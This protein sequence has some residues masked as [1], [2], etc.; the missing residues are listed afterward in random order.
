MDS[1]RLRTETGEIEVAGR[2]I[3]TGQDGSR[4]L[5]GRDG[6]LWTI[7]PG[8]VLAHDED[9]RPFEGVSKDEMARILLAELPQGFQVVQTAHYVIAYE[10]SRDY[11]LWCGGLFER[12]F[13]AFNNYFSRRGFELREP[14]VP[15]AAIVY[16]SRES[17]IRNNRDEVGDGVT[18]ILGFYNLETNR[19]KLFD[20]SGGAAR[21]NAAQIN[22]YLNRPE[23]L[24]NLATVIHEATHQ[25]A[26]NSG[27]NC[28]WTDTPLWLSEGIAVY[29]ETPDVR[30]TR[31]WST[32]DV[33]NRPR[34]EQ[35][36]QYLPRRPAV[37]LRTLIADDARFRDVDQAA[38]AYAETW[39]LTYFLLHRKPKE[40]VAYLRRLQE[41]KPL[42]WDDADTRIADFEACFG[43]LQQ[44]DK[45]FLRYF[46][47][48]R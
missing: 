7:M 30:S 6:R 36:R 19:M 42:I 13:T 22:R 3:A 12:L 17:F 27:L 23:M 28:R 18:G 32:S 14:I 2:V 46:S 26:Y 15:L 21:G 48:L 41:K 31:G 24:A 40:Y 20:L 10:T 33:I 9:L 4:M 39:A 35:M 45:E 16:G 47:Q 29:F 11:A 8:D 38:D 1:F 5:L 37:S 25:I 34:Y 43:D 44:L